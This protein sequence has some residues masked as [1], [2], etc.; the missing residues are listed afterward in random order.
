[1]ALSPKRNLRQILK[2]YLMAGLLV[3]VPTWGTWLILSALFRSI[4]GLLG[5]LLAGYLRQN[6]FPGLGI[7]SLFFLVLGTGVLVSNLVGRRLLALWE[8][9]LRGV[10]VV[11][12]VYVSIKAILDTFA[13]QQRRNL[14]RVVLV[15]YPRKGQFAIGFLTGE[16]SEITQG[17]ADRR[18]LNVFVPTTPNPT[19]GFLVITREDEVRPLNISIEEGMRMIFSGGLYSPGSS[20]EAGD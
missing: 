16:S 15:E 12:N 8:G 6:Y 13:F 5:K 11:R 18:M 17:W 4:E 3:V 9:L 14:Q 7:L 1:M 19:S 20:A 10:P 2:K